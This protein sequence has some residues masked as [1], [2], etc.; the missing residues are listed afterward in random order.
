MHKVAKRVINKLGGARNVAL[1]IGISVQA[2]YKWT[3]P[4]DEGGTGGL[5]PHRRQIELMVASKQHGIVL[6]PSDFFPK[7]TPKDEPPEVSSIAE[8]GTDT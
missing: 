5:I 7:G 3:Y 8:V 4:I 6:T 2:V 1:M